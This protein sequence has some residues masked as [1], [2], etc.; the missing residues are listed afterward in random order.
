MRHAED[1]SIISNAVATHRKTAIPQVTI[2][3]VIISLRKGAIPSRTNIILRIGGIVNYLYLFYRVYMITVDHALASS[4]PRVPS[5]MKYLQ[6]SR[7]HLAHA[8]GK[9]PTWRSSL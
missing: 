2:A 3:I 5:Y 9:N 1:F 6:V 7:D 8:A 4:A